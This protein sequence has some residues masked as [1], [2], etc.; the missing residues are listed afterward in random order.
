MQLFFENQIEQH[1]QCVQRSWQ[2][3]YL[4][5]YALYNFIK[6]ASESFCSIQPQIC[7]QS[8]RYML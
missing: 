7:T 6:P 8:L 3:K 2:Y 1:V 4:D 5:S